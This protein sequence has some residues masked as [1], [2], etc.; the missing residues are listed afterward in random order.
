M[1]YISNGNSQLFKNVLNITLIITEMY[2]KTIM[3]NQIRIVIMTIIKNLL[4]Q[5]QIE[6]Q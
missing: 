4:L 5:F 3:K 6:I 1:K 2:T